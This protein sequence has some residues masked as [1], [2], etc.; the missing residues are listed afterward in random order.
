ML[1]H[2]VS[3]SE[4]FCFLGHEFP[5]KGARVSLLDANYLGENLHNTIQ[6]IL[7]L[8]DNPLNYKHDEFSFHNK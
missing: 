7:V 8:T 4:S 6:A 5:P 1:L 2:D 3:D